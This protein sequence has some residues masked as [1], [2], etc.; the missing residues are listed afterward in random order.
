AE[1]APASDGM[2]IGS[3][4]ADPPSPPDIPIERREPLLAVAVHVGGRV[5]AGLLGGLEPGH[6]QRARRWAALQAERTA[7][8][9]PRVIGRR[10]R[11]VLHP[12]EVRQAMRIR[13]RLHA[14]ARR[15]TFVA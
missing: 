3:R 15:P 7:V 10:R 1:V 11:A 8:A 14:G 6:E 9:A 5:V 2:E 13:P 4:R 12:L